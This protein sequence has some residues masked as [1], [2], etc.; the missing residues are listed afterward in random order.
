MKFAEYKEEVQRTL[1]HLGEWYGNPFILDSLHCLI[2]VQ[3]EHYELTNALVKEDIY[4]IGEEITDK[5]WYATNYCNVRAIVPNVELISLDSTYFMNL[6]DLARQQRI[7]STSGQLNLAMSEL[8]DYDKK[9]WAYRKPVSEYIH[10]RRVE[11][12]NTVLSRINDLY[13]L[14]G[15]DAEKCMEQNINKLKARFPE[16]FDMDKANNRD[17]ETER[18]TLEN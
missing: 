2:G 10:N 8:F 1:P 9:E 16:K 18:K 6:P 15:L 13:A 12:I 4:N 5:A 7:L 11:L 17:L 14:N 3:S